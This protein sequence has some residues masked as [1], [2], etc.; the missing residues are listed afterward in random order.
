MMKLNNQMEFFY[1]T[2]YFLKNIK[3]D[4]L[5]IHLVVVEVESSNIICDIL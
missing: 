2:F 5:S 1:F 4:I 3:K